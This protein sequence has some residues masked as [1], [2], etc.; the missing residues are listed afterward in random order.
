MK[1]TPD[2]LKDVMGNDTLMAVSS[3]S[4]TPQAVRKSVQRMHA[5]CPSDTTQR[6]SGLAASPQ[7]HA[8]RVFLLEALQSLTS[9]MYCPLY[10]STLLDAPTTRRLS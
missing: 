10:T 8:Q 5:L 9:L 6:F 2:T 4:A 3:P 1:P 7:S